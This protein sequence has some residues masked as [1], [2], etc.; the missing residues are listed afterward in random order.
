MRV[1]DKMV[2]IALGYA[3]KD[4]DYQVKRNALQ[5]LRNLGTGAKLAEP[6]VS[7]LLTD[8]DPQ[9]RLDAFHTLQ[10]LGVDPRPGLKKALSHPDPAIRINTAS[11]MTQL[12]LEV[13]LAEPVLLEGLKEKDQAL[14]MQA[15]YALSQR[16][17]QADVVLPIFI[18]GLKNELP[19]VRRQAAEA[20]ARYG[21]KAS[22]AAPSLIDALDDGDDG[23]R[24]A[25]LTTL[26]QVGAEPKAMFAAMVKVLRNKDGKLHGPAA[27]FLFQVGPEVVGEMV[28]ML[29]TESAPALRLTCLQVLAMIGP[30][31]KEGVS[32]L[33]KALEDP[34]A[35]ARMTAARAL[36][37]IGPDAKAAV[38]ALTKAEKD[39]DANVQKIVKAALAQIRAD[40]Q[41]KDFQI[42]GVLTAGD[43]FD[44]VRQG[45][46]HV[47]HTY[48]MKT[49]QTYTIDLIS[50]WD[51][52]L[53]LENSLGDQLAQDDD[54]GGNLNARIVFT[55]PK[56]GWYRIIVTS[57][58]QNVSGEYTLKVR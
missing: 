35:R 46:Y 39:A 26:R 36:G 14:K 51:N 29:K 37:N 12:N 21:T 7:A 34:V 3:T 38:E 57:F 23:V 54:S 19:S 25:A 55:A 44:R 41:A 27:Q 10:G 45:C 48:P 42:Q 17:L 5:A 43:P 32:E 18:A 16:G 20:L 56:D 24:A 4:K 50:S 31:A 33:I 52:F 28:A 2:V 30:P 8:I 15:A 40:A 13:D 1:N 11:L 22:K 6:Y 9:I 49:G 53:R 58:G 47:V